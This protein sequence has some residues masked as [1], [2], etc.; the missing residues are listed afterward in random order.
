MSDDDRQRLAPPAGVGTPTEE[1]WEYGYLYFV[2]TVAP[3]QGS[4][5]PVAG[6]TVTVV[7]DGAGHRCAVL[8]GRR[9]EV[10]NELGGAGWVI[11]DGLWNPE[12]VRWLAEAV[13]AVDG[14]DRMV[15]YWQSFMRRRVGG[16]PDGDGESPGGR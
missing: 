4:Q 15:G 11:S 3:A 5:P 9:L 2:H 6:P 16:D 7:A 10:L 12:Q 1:R 8:A 14:V 13:G